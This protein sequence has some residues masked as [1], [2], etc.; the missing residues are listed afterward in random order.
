MNAQVLTYARAHPYTMAEQIFAV[1]ALIVMGCVCE[2]TAPRAYPPSR[3]PLSSR[4]H[5][6]RRAPCARRRR[7]SGRLRAGG[8][9]PGPTGL[10]TGHRPP[11]YLTDRMSSLVSP[12][13]VRVSRRHRA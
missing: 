11:I 10:P 12:V 13:Y 3:P 1:F 9:A 7:R 4:R 2:Y 5:G 6:C 8:D